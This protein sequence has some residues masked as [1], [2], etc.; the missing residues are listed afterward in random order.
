MWGRLH[1]LLG[2]HPNFIAKRPNTTKLKKLLNPPVFNGGPEM[3]PVVSDGFFRFFQNADA[4]STDDN[5][6]FPIG[7]PKDTVTQDQLQFWRD[8]PLLPRAKRPSPLFDKLKI[9]SPGSADL[10][11]DPPRPREAADVLPMQILD[12]VPV[13]ESEASKETMIQINLP[14]QI[15]DP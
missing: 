15:F 13:P 10:H 6:S 9:A 5:A 14:M 3:I 1:N 11:Q 7:I 4:N 2:E 8:L 12:P